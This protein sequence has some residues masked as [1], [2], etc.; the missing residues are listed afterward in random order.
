MNPIHRLV[1]PRLWAASTVGVLL[2][3]LVIVA[4]VGGGFF[5]NVVLQG[6]SPG[7][8]F[9]GASSLVSL[10]DL[11]QAL[12]K[13]G[14]FGF[15]AAAIACHRGM[16][17]TRS[18]VGVGL[19]VKQAVVVTFLVVFAVNYLITSLYFVLVP[20]AAG[21]MAFPVAAPARSGR[22]LAGAS[23]AIASPRSAVFSVFACRALYHAVFDVILRLKHRRTVVLHVSDIVA[24][25]GRVRGRRRAWCSSSPRWHS[26]LALRSVSRRSAGCRSSVPSRSSG[27]SAPTPTHVRSR[28]S[29]PPSRCRRR[30]ARRSRPS[31]RHAHLRGGRRARGDVGAV[32]HVPR[33]HRAWWRW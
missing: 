25:A 19:A 17:C 18:P 11:G 23:P 9:Q 8:Y 32:A 7:A 2:V 14:L 5:F 12:V 28:R 29:S 6:V 4:G 1:T 26:P 16:T 33:V 3:S 13:A 24:G 21:L 20:P 10:P 31:W 15:I 22:P 27:W 30:S